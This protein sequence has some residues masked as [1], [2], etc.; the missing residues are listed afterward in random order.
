MRDFLQ[1]IRD[2]DKESA[3]VAVVIIWLAYIIAYSVN[4]KNKK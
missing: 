2:Y 3:F 4:K 1:A